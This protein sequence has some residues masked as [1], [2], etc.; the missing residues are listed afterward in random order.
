MTR[1]PLPVSGP[2]DPIVEPPSGRIEDATPHRTEG[3]KL[4]VAEAARASAQRPLVV[5]VGGPV[6]SIADAFLLEP[7]I[8]DRVIV[9]WAER[10]GLERWSGALSLG[11]GGCATKLYMR[12][13]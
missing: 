12:L 6:S 11:H 7:G 1:V 4:I 3:A 5:V 2:G 10:P 13:I 9:A 8:V